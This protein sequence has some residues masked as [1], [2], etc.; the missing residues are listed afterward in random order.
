MV[1]LDYFCTPEE[2]RQFIGRSARRG[3]QRSVQ[4]FNL[5]CCKVDEVNYARVS[6]YDEVNSEIRKRE[7]ILPKE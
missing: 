4:I 1:A 5:T 3:Q 6:E 2:Y 7:A